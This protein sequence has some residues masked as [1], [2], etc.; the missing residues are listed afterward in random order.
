MEV[1]C[2]QGTGG[3]LKQRL[4]IERKESSHETE[5]MLPCMIRSPP[6]LGRIPALFSL[7]LPHIQLHSYGIS[8]NEAGYHSPR[9]ARGAL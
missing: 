5:Y 8:L 4:G 6:R 9:C 2:G 7:G 1:Q 3:D